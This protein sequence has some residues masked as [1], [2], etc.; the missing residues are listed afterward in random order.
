M[1]NVGSPAQLCM[2]RRLNSLLPSTPEQLTP[3]V[4]DPNKVIERMKQNQEVSKE[5]YDRG[6]R[7]LSELN[8]N[9]TVRMQ[10]QDKWVPCTVVRQADTPRSYIVK[11]LNGQE[12]HRN[13]KHLR[14]VN[15]PPLT[16][17]DVEDT[18]P[19][20]Q[21]PPVEQPN[22]TTTTTDESNARD[23]IVKAPTRYKDFVRHS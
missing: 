7:Q 16:T 19:A 9:D 2:S 15:G 5:Y 14:K 17:I 6:A 3:H 20:P 1:N 11:G 13:R 18:E 4:V 22:S 21:P 23:R 12:Y 10:V 8:P